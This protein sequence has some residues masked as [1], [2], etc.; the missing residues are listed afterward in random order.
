MT[1]QFLVL[2][3][4]A[5]VSVTSI[6]PSFSSAPSV[7]PTTAAPT[8]IGAPA[9]SSARLLGF[10]VGGM[11]PIYAAAKTTIV[12]D[13]EIT[14][15]SS[16]DVEIIG[17]N[18]V[19]DGAG[20]SRLFVVDSGR[21]TLRSLELRHGYTTGNGG[22]IS[23]LNGAFVEIINC[24]VSESTAVSG[25]AASVD[26]GSVLLIIGSSVIGS[27]ASNVKCLRLVLLSRL[28]TSFSR[29]RIIVA[30]SIGMSRD[31]QCTSTVPKL[32][33]RRRDEPTLE[34]RRQQLRQLRQCELAR[35]RSRL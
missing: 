7:S 23:L 19:F 28:L 24:V 11:T 8:A 1:F 31:R 17:E 34:R 32:V 27:H 21:L 30:V 6:A 33:T 29:Q 4:S 12:V 18:T 13:A 5:S 9:G 22:A 16:S 25:G 14:L 2:C 3:I 26:S 35:V 10:I 20:S 15:D